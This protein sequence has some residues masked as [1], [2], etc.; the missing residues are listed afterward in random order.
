MTR[1][2]EG[3]VVLVTGGGVR[4]GRAIAEGVGRLGASVAVHYSG[5]RAGANDAVQAISRD[6][7]RA[8]AFQADLT[9]EESVL[10]LVEAV[11]SGLGPIHALV[12]SAAIF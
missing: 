8:Q 9:R 4:L 1:P 12:N 10:A 7:N 6:G 3:K 2:L 11:E 5:S